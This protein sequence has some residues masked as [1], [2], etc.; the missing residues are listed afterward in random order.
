MS[1]TTVT[2]SGQSQ[3]VL[4][5]QHPVLENSE[6]MVTLETSKALGA[7]SGPLYIF[8]N[9]PLAHPEESHQ[10]GMFF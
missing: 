4:E 5:R 8:N 7:E 2:L 1:W 10:W 9:I 6:F 3:G